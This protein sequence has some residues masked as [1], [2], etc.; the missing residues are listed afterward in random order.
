MGYTPRTRA[1][2]ISPRILP[3]AFCLLL[4]SSTTLLL[5]DAVLNPSN[6]PPLGSTP[7]VNSPEVRKW[8]S[9]L[10]LSRAPSIETNTGEPPECPTVVPEDVCYWTCD[11][12]SAD[13][14]VECPNP[15]VWGLTFDDGPTPATPELLQFLEEKE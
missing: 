4:L 7:S 3:A 8:L 5:A 13:D 2:R 9:E 10:D 6:Y 15:G 14:V 1:T 11:D 12:C